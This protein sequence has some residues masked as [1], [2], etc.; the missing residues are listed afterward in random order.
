MFL[1]FTEIDLNK[2]PQG[3][4]LFLAFPNRKIIAELYEGYEKSQSIKLGALNEI[5]FK[6]PFELDINH[7]FVRNPHIDQ[8][9]K[10]FLIKVQSGLKFEWYIIDEILD[11]TDDNS[12]EIH[13]FS[14]GY[15][16]SDKK[17]IRYECV[18][19]NATQV[20]HDALDKTIWTIG[21]IDSK[22]D[23]KYR[24][25]N[26]TSKTVLDFVYEIANTFGALVVF[27]TEDRTVNF[28]D[29]EN[30]GL[31]KGL[32]LSYDKYLDNL[33]KIEN[34]DNVKTRLRIF[35]KDGLSIHEVNITGQ[36]YIED[37]S[38]YMYPFERDENR[39]VLKHSAY[40]MSDELCHAILDYNELLASKQGEFQGY[41]TNKKSL[42]QTK[43]VKQNELTILQD[44]LSIILDNID[45]AQANSLPVSD[46]LT[47][48]VQK[49]S[50]IATKQTEINGINGQITSVTNSINSLS[51]SLKYENNFT[52][53]Q[54]IELNP[55]IIEEEWS[56]N[57]Y[58]DAQDLYNDGVKRLN[59]LKLGTPI[60]EVDIVNFL[61]IVTA[62]RDWDKLN[63]G[64]IIT[65]QYEKFNVGI[66]AKIVEIDYQDD[67]IKLIISNIKDILNDKEKFLK[68]IQTSISTS[69][70][71]NMDKFKW[72]G[73]DARVNN[74]EAILNN[75]WNAALRQIKAGTNESVDISRRGITLSDPNNPSESIRLM[76]NVIGC[77]LDGFN[78]LGVAISPK[79]VHAERLF[80]RIIAGQNLTIDASNTE[81]E[82]FFEVNETGVEISGMALTITGGLPLNQI[83][84]EGILIENEYYNGVKIDSTEGLI[85][86]RN[87]NK[88][89]SGMNATDGIFI[90]KYESS[91]WNKK[92]YAD[93]DGNLIIK[94]F[95]EIG[96]GNTIFKA[97]S[98]GI[99]LGSS[100]FNY[101]PF[102]VNLLGYLTA[103]GADI[104]GS[105]DCSS[106]KIAGTDVLTSLYQIR[107]SAVQ[108][109]TIQNLNANNITTGKL[110]ASMIDTIGLKAQYIQDDVY[111]NTMLHLN[112][113]EL[114]FSR[115]TSSNFMGIYLGSS[116]MQIHYRD[117]NYM[118]I[119]LSGGQAN[120]TP[121]GIW[122]FGSATVQN[123]SATAVFG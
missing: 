60:I 96:S 19:Y 39:N 74:V 31:N 28:Y 93:I 21:Y 122:N 26:I 1:V 8:I 41:L 87:D 61:K 9:K 123:L 85:V 82:K 107:G 71:V 23:V 6:L 62:Q 112:N 12:K 114:I 10:R 44:E 89:R 109:S 78:S 27:N 101:A 88:I 118:S 2:E 83:D 67:E 121:Y 105:I 116:N 14:L 45:I 13:A 120:V 33:N 69:T 65:V 94:G 46:L 11:N 40:N 4:R 38:Y 97:D 72:N 51:D 43:T 48:K 50:E 77:T 108:G 59:E 47:Q 104:Q 55:Y 66:Q 80:G 84:A 81:G 73:A 90:E 115:D 42:Q 18:S 100:D 32:Y 7:E 111:A 117:A 98:N 64:D 36:N 63:I 37:F 30:Y 99:Y 49:E 79:G 75:E 17:I 54:I 25:F 20:L 106:L 56:D 29:L 15:E 103:S 53:S 113:N 5:T 110:S 95:I 102:K 57:N 24:S 119:G 22:F 58:I 16:L 92:L 52:P 34:L 68:M 86:T 3:L 91:Q 76:H 70:E 35:G